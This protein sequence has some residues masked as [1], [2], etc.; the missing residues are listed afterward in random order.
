VAYGQ[1]LLVR[2][3]ADLTKQFGRGF[4]VDNLELMRLFYQT[5]PPTAISESLIRKSTGELRPGNSETVVQNFDLDQLAGV[6][7]LSWA[8]YT[9]LMRLTRSAEERAFYEAE[10]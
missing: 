3:P 1:A 4:G 6:F 8:H 5:W 9:H 2:L 7:Q 10:A